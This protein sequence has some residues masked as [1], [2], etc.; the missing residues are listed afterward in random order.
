MENQ[1][2]LIKV[3]EYSTAYFAGIYEITDDGGEL[4]RGVGQLEDKNNERVKHYKTKGWAER[5]KSNL[6]K[7]FGGDGV[8]FEVVEDDHD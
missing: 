6:I 4:F 7:E 8:S 1:T 2:W 3:H 5:T